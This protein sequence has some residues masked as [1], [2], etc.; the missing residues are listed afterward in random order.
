MT[1]NT[2]DSKYLNYMVEENYKLKFVIKKTIKVK[3]DVKLVSNVNWFQCKNYYLYNKILIIIIIKS[4]QISH[5]YK[6]R[7]VSLV[8]FFSRQR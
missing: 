3:S 2:R 4:N 7:V 5:P 8:T 6:I 1:R